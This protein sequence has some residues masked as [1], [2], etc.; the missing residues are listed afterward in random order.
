[1]LH[2]NLKELEELI[3]KDPKIKSV[4]LDLVYPGDKVRVLN[5]LDVIQPRCKIDEADADFPGFVGKMQTAG[6]GRTRSLRGIVVLVSNPDTHRKENALLDMDGPLAEMSPYGKM[7]NVVI[8]PHIADGVEIREFEDA[9]K[10]AGLKTAVYLAQGAE[11]HS[12]AETEVYDLDI[13]SVN[14]KTD[15][16][17]IAY[18]YQVYSPQFDFMKQSDAC[19]YGSDVTGMMRIP[20]LKLSYLR[21]RP[22]A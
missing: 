9:V 18:Y 12:V 19:L 5:L 17:R 14:H 2:V 22:P 4:E 21:V 15:L 8:A 20:L 3:L 11:G 7:R 13:P 6:S 1:M 10:L 16:P